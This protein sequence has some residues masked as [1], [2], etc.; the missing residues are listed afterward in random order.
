VIVYVSTALARSGNIA[1]IR[2]AEEAGKE[3]RRGPSSVKRGPKAQPH[4]AR[5]G[6]SGKRG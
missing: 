6:S 3:H 1:R 4:A 2:A 5:R